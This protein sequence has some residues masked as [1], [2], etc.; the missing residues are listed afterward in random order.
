M[1]YKKED[2]S[3]LLQYKKKYNRL[4]TKEGEEQ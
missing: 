3:Y 1:I 2:L 4:N